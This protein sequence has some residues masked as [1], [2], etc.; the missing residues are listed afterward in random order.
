METTRE[1]R[2]RQERD[3][4]RIEKEDISRSIEEKRR[5]GFQTSDEDGSELGERMRRMSP[6]APLF[7][8]LL[9]TIMIASLILSR[10]RMLI[11]TLFA[12]KPYEYEY[13]NVQD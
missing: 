12:L 13:A 4:Q 10:S 7:F 6:A 9:L 3:Q 2:T 5:W 1:A 8:L 11:I